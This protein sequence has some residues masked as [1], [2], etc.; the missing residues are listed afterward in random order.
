MQT[1]SEHDD[2]LEQRLNR[3]AVWR[4]GANQLATGPGPSPLAKMQGEGSEIERGSKRVDRA[5]SE[6]RR[7]YESLATQYRDHKRLC[8]TL[9]VEH[10]EHGYHRAQAERLRKALWGIARTT[11]RMAWASLISGTGMR[12]EPDYP[13]EERTQAAVVA[14]ADHLRDVIEGI[15]LSPMPAHLRAVEMGISERT[16]WYRLKQAKIEINRRLSSELHSV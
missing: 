7:V 9:T 10:Q 12:K 4:R 14:L 8:A 5:E 16:V 1:E 13:E 6:S 11:G 3:W 2:A 15:Y